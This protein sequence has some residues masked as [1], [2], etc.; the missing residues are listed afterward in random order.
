M[1]Y[2]DIKKLEQ[3][4]ITELSKKT[5]LFWAFNEKQFEE[6]KTP[7]KKGDKY[8]SI[9]QGG[10]LPKSNI[11]EFFTGLE[12]IE[13]WKK[14]EVKKNKAESEK[15]ILYELNNY[16]SFYSADI[17][18]AWQV[19]KNLGFTRNQVMAVYKKNYKFAEL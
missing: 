6:S 9:N 15:T 3:E 19:L 16:E 11:D 10:Y 14:T 12:N 7:L 4:K 1:D 17:T 2:Q 5:G 13:K 8:V 18:D